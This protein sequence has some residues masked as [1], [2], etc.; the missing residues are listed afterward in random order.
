MGRG[1][2]ADRGSA[3]V[4]AV[5]AIA[6]LCAVFGAVL[7][8]GQAVVIRH[9][10]EAAADLAALAAADHWMKGAEGACATAERVVQAQGGRLVRCAVEGEISDVTAASGTVPFTAE[11]RA[12]AG[13]PGRAADREAH[14]GAP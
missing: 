8:F 12:R 5:G 4:W 10:A 6:V 14:R 13:P 1:R 2:E 11:S 9:Q 3:T 7:A